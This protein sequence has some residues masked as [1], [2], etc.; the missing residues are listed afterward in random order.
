MD[1]V[2]IDDEGFE[3]TYE[4]LKLLLILLWAIVAKGMF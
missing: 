1:E 3:P 2:E 4:G